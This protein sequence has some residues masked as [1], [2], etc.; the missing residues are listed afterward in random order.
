LRPSTT[1]ASDSDPEYLEKHSPYLFPLGRGGFGGTRTTKFLKKHILLI[2]LISAQGRFN[3]SIFVAVVRY[4]YSARSIQGF[5]GTFK[6]HRDLN[7][8]TVIFLTG[9]HLVDCLLKPYNM[10]DSTN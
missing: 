8:E 6:I 2:G 1:F 3:M 7:Q 5:V 9:K 4:D 10:L